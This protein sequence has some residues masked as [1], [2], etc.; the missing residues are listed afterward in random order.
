MVQV[1]NFI[2]IFIENNRFEIKKSNIKD[3]IKRNL[4][5]KSVCMK[6]TDESLINHLNEQNIQ[7][8]TLTYK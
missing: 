5:F 3:D 1:I 4:S 2:K 6:Y 7:T 8:E